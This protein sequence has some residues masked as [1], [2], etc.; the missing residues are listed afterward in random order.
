VKEKR[1]KKQTLTMVNESSMND[2]EDWNDMINAFPIIFFEK[3]LP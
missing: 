1:K 3:G 2:G